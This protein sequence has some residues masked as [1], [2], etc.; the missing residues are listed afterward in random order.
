MY[1]RTTICTRPRKLKILKS[2]FF[3]GHREAPVE[4]KQALD[5]AVKLHIR[6][7]GVL[8]YCVGDYGQYDRMAQN[9]LA[10]AK[11]RHPDIRIHMLIPYYPSE[12]TPY[13]PAGFDDFFY[14]PGL[15]TVPCPAAIVRANRYMAENSDYIIAYVRHATSNARNILEY[16]EKRGIH[17]E[18]LAKK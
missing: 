3:I 18:N 13:L 12:R 10:R 9:A 14:P 5:E 2:C 8:D 4:I 16:A 11:K 1:N 7:Y 6:D 15:E 17:I